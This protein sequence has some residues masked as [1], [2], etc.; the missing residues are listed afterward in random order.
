MTGTNNGVH[1]LLKNATGNDNLILVRCVCHSLQLALSHASEETLPRNVEFLIRETYNWFSHSSNRRL[2]YKNIYQTMNCGSEPLSIPQMCNTR[3]ISIEPAVNRILEQWVELKLLFEVAKRDNPCYMA[4]TPY[5]MYN[6]PSNHLYLL[7]LKPI[8]EEVQIVNKLFESN[9]VD[10]T[11]LY[12]DLCGL[13]KSIS[14]RIL[15]PTAR[16]DIFTQNIESFLDPKPYMGYAFESRLR[17]Y[18][19]QPDVEN[20]LRQRCLNFT[21]KLVTEL[22]SRLPINFKILEKLSFFSV[23]QL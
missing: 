6:D 4:E 19:I 16:V 5:T 7:Y 21:L 15:N 9:N 13:V 10:P 23:E 20:N 17:E 11:K 18:N 1:A 8:L 14:R 22:R 2:H 3:W 12:K